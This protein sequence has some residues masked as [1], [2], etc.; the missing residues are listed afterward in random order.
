MCTRFKEF[1]PNSI[2]SDFFVVAFFFSSGTSSI[3][4]FFSSLPSP[5]LLPASAVV[6]FPHTIG[7]IHSFVRADS[8][9]Y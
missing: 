7:A 8:E 6:N 9:L 3:L 4:F 5:P 1:R 2:S